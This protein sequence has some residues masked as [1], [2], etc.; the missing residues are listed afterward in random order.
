MIVDSVNWVKISGSFIA[1]S[2]YKFV[3]IGNFLTDLNTDTV[4][5]GSPSTFFDLSPGYASY[6]YI[7]DICVS[8]DSVTCNLSTDIIDYEIMDRIQIF[9]NPA[10]NII[11]IENK[12]PEKEIDKIMIYNSQGIIEV[13]FYDF[14]DNYINLA[15][16][17]SGLYFVSIYSGNLII[18]RKFIIN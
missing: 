7:D 2:S 8:E 1:D 11:Y 13:I 12:F 17:R 5:I 3:E 16:F 4:I 10:N 18:T 6:Y 15:N 14:K 9:P